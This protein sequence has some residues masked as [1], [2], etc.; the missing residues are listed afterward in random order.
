MQVKITTRTET[1]A[2]VVHE[3]TFSSQELLDLYRTADALL[4]ALEEDTNPV[5]EERTFQITALQAFLT[6]YT[7]EKEKELLAFIAEESSLVNL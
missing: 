5:T 6:P 4:A 1:R 7:V 2:K 3:L